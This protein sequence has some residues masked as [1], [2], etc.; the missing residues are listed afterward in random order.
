MCGSL[1]NYLSEPSGK[2]TS[3]ETHTLPVCSGTER[4]VASRHTYSSY[5][6]TEIVKIK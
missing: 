2:Q 6:E 5:K 3:P 1:E 4:L